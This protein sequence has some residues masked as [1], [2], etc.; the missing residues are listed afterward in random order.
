MPSKRVY[1]AT[2]RPL[3][4][5]QIHFRLCNLVVL[6][7]ETNVVGLNDQLQECVKLQLIARQHSHLR[8][9]RNYADDADTRQRRRYGLEL[10]EE[11]CLLRV[12]QDQR[13]HPGEDLSINPPSRSYVGRQHEVHTDRVHVQNDGDEEQHLVQRAVLQQLRLTQPTRPDAHLVTLRVLLRRL[14]DQSDRHATPHT[15]PFPPRRQ[16]PLARQL[17]AALGDHQRASNVPAHRTH[18]P[19]AQVDRLGREH[20]QLLQPL[21]RV[22]RRASR[23]VDDGGDLFAGVRLEQHAVHRHATDGAQRHHAL[24][25]VDGV[26]DALFD[27]P[28]AAPTMTMR[29]ELGSCGQS[30][31]L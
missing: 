22:S 28:P 9:R 8:R 2:N 1:R 27:T 3:C 13:V 19:A 12:P 20:R 26:G 10:G 7:R 21:L 5:E 31:S 4:H 30:N 29:R 11:Q 25:Q 17:H 14:R 6:Q 24:G 15:P 16:S 23:H 18:L